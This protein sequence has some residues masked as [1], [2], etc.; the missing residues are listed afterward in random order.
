[1]EVPLRPYKSP[2]LG[3][4]VL[5]WL[6]IKCILIP[7]QLLF[8]IYN[9]P[10]RSSY[11]IWRVGHGRHPL[12]TPAKPHSDKYLLSGGKRKPQ[13]STAGI[14]T[15]L[16]VSGTQN[17]HDTLADSATKQKRICPLLRMRR[18]TYKLPTQPAMCAPWNNQKNTRWLPSRWGT[19]VCNP[20]KDVNEAGHILGGWAA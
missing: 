5:L 10:K 17:S 18:W 7:N 3:C 12:K 9:G 4:G 13:H 14:Q 15:H 6:F 2:V 11:L 20:F 1:M 8:F 16:S 19:L